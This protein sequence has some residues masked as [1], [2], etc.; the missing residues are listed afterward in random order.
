M[1]SHY[2]EKCKPK[3]VSEA[4]PLAPQIVKSA[5]VRGVVVDKS[6][7]RFLA[8]LNDRVVPGSL[9]VL[10]PGG[11]VT[12]GESDLSVLARDLEDSLGMNDELG[13]GNC[14]FLMNRNY[15]SSV[16][17]G[18]CETVRVNFYAVV[19]DGAVPRNLHPE[20]IVSIGWMT[21]EELTA[22]VN[23]EGWK[24]QLGAAEAIRAALGSTASTEQPAAPKTP[25]AESA[26]PLR[27]LPY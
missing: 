14:R 4:A 1:S 9:T 27:V 2:V 8:I 3:S 20:S 24:L 5:R 15:E 6:N 13:A 16:P 26:V 21:I 25:V 22:R 23:S 11:D 17:G 10:L 19:S 12:A 7:G 18:A